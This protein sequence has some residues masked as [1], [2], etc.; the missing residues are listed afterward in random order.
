MTLPIHL[1]VICIAPPPIIVSFLYVLSL[2]YYQGS[3]L[4]CIM[5][6]RCVTPSNP[7]PFPARAWLLDRGPV[8]GLVCL[9]LSFLIC[10]LRSGR[11][12]DRLAKAQALLRHPGIQAPAPGPAG[13]N[14]VSNFFTFFLKLTKSKVNTTRHIHSAQSFH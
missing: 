6:W 1:H 7:L 12:P 8:T 3:L 4:I 11:T 2:T 9:S 14:T 5:Q 10:S 13:M